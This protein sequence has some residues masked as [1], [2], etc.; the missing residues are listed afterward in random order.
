Q[1]FYTGGAE[2][3]NLEALLGE[4]LAFAIS[5]RIQLA[6]S[7]TFYPALTSA[8]QYNFQTNSG[9]VFKLTKRFTANIDLID[10]YLSN[11]TPGNHKNNVALTAGLGIVF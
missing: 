10:D 5:K 3:Q 8:G 9:L 2:Q 11:P 4:T 6:H 1:R 7:L